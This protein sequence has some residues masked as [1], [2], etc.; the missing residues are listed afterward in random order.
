MENLAKVQAMLA[1]IFVDKCGHFHERQKIYTRL[2]N[3]EAYLDNFISKI[4]K[5]V[6]N[7]SFLTG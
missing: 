1:D 4:N 7:S 6:K 3:C 5:N 2:D